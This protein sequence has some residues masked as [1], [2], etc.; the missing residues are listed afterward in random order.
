MKSE[1]ATDDKAT[2][3]LRVLGAVEVNVVGGGDIQLATQAYQAWMTCLKSLVDSKGE[4]QKALA[5]FS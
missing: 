4:T 1:I 3:E 5:R 2:A